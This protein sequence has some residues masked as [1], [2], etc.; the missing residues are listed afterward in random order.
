MQTIREWIPLNQPTDEMSWKAAFENQVYFVRDILAPLLA[1]N[2]EEYRNLIKVCSTHR[3]KSIVLPVYH[4]FLMVGEQTVE[5]WMR[6]NF[7]NCLK[8]FLYFLI[9]FD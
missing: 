1:R 4:L 8:M 6:D 2:G 3:S 7:Y 5:C 9:H